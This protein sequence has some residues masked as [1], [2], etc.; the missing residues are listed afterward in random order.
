MKTKIYLF[1]LFAQFV[2]LL[3]GEGMQNRISA[4]G[5]G[6]ACS[7]AGDIELKIKTK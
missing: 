2:F 7:L 4:N 1:R 5:S 6:L 3:A